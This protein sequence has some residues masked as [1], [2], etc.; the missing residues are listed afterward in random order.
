MCQRNHICN[1]AK[2]CFFKLHNTFKIRKCITD[3]AAKTMVNSMITSK[4]DYCN[5]IF[6]ALPD[7][8]LKSLSSVQKTALLLIGTK[9]YELI[10]PVIPNLHWLPIRRRIMYNI[11]VL[12]LKCLLGTA[13]GYLVDLLQKRHNKRTRDDDR[14]FLVIPKVKRSTFA[15][16]SFSFASATLWNRLPDDLSLTTDIDVFKK[17]LKSYIFSLSYQL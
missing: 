16:R 8:S 6:C 13:P 3:E 9:R 11:L 4:L 1:V 5:S 7:C 12:T 2:G 15:G 14:N 10:T 17:Q